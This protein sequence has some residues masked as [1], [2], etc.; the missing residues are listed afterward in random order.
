M[1]KMNMCGEMTVQ[2]DHTRP[3]V[4]V[5][6][7]AKLQALQVRLPKSVM[8]VNSSASFAAGAE[9]NGCEV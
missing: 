2:T 3:D 4:I 7:V 6:N 9:G 8:G 1:L 5:V